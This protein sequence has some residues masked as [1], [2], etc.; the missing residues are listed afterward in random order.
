MSTQVARRCAGPDCH[1]SPLP[2]VNGLVC[3]YCAD[4]LQRALADMFGRAPGPTVTTF[5]GA[6]GGNA[7]P[8]SAA[9]PG[10][11]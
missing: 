1:R 6:A 3:A 11:I 8:L 10:R 2:T 4:C 5:K 9:A 7:A